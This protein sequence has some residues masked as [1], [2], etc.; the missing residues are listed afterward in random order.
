MTSRRHLRK[1]GDDERLLQAAVVAGG[2]LD[3]DGGERFVRH[4]VSMLS[5]FFPSSL[6]TRHNKLEG[7]SF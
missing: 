6:T 5:T 1:D 2:A 4:L 3:E 7:L